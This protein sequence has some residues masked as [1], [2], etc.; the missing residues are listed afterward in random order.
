[1]GESMHRLLEEFNFESVQYIARHESVQWQQNDN[2]Q[3]RRRI[4]GI[5]TLHTFEFTS[6][7]LWCFMNFTAL[8]KSGHRFHSSL[9][10]LLWQWNSSYMCE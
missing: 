6:H 10:L 8:V 1:M 7:G 5:N 9:K 2:I 4:H 3:T